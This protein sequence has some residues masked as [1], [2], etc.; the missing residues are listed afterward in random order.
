[1]CNMNLSVTWRCEWPRA[2]P[3]FRVGGE[4]GWHYLLKV[5]AWKTI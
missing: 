4:G 3:P 1:M 2:M 5:I